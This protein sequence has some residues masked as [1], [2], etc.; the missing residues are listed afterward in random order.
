MNVVNLNIQISKLFVKM[1]N[2]MTFMTHMLSKQFILIR[3]RT[4]IMSTKSLII[5]PENK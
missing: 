5:G 3:R 1:W 2:I 4:E